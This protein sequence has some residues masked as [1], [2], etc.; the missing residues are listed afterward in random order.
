MSIPDP[1]LPND[2]ANPLFGPCLSRLDAGLAT[3]ADG[4]QA[5]ALGIRTPSTT[6]TVMLSAEKLDTG[7]GHLGR[8]HHQAGRPAAQQAWR[9]RVRGRGGGGGR[10]RRVRGG[11]ARQP[12]VGPVPGRCHPGCGLRVRQ[13]RRLR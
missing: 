9:G 13:P 2:P 11:A 4:T 7:A 1:L 8:S 6:L 5:G 3:A 12:G 10:G